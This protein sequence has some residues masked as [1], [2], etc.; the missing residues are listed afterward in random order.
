MCRESWP[1]IVLPQF[2]HVNRSSFHIYLKH[3]MN[4]NK[5]QEVFYFNCRT[6]HVS[7]VSPPK[8]IYSPVWF[9]V[10]TSCS[11]WACTF[12]YFQSQQYNMKPIKMVS[13]STLNKIINTTL[14]FCPHFLWA[15]LKDLRLFLCT[16]NTYFSQ[17]LF[18]NMSKSVLVSTCPL[19]R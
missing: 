4:M 12:T 6:H 7:S 15:E 5:H 13:K 9:V 2:K 18:T 1:I 3:E 19:P 11:Y 16:Q 17:I 14:L 10:K 8:L